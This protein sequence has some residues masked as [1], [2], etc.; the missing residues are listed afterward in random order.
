MH[1]W[2]GEL[3]VIV[4]DPAQIRFSTRALRLVSFDASFLRADLGGAPIISTL[5]GLLSA[6]GGLA[7]LPTRLIAAALGSI[8]LAVSTW[9]SLV[10][11]ATAAGDLI[12]AAAGSAG[13]AA[14][15][16]A[17][18]EAPIAALGTAAGGAPGT[19]SASALATAI[20]D[21]SEAIASVALGGAS[22]AIGSAATPT[23][24][25]N[26]DPRAG[27][28]L[29]LNLSLEI[30]ALATVGVIDAAMR[31]A[32]EV[33]AVAAATR[34]AADIDFESRDEA[35][36]WTA[37]LSE[38][39]DRLVGRAGELAPDAPAAAAISLSALG[40]VAAALGSDMNEI[41]GRL[42]A[43]SRITPA[44]T[45]SAWLIAQHLAGD[46]P[47]N[48]VAM[49]DDIVVRNRLRH[50]AQISPDGVEVLL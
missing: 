45:V 2:L 50:P 49:L 13:H 46:S 24:A 10:T 35:L 39:I 43:V 31:M 34:V 32:A 11:S 37:R 44:G 8:S 1:P 14:Q 4:A 38:G 3:T 19:A 33:A 30:D 29:L 22:P 12:Q 48:V 17:A 28:A 47:A 5:A 9:S 26:A 15:L 25:V 40:A 20:T 36:A 23:T 16:T 41:I 7:T 21:A 27:A 42:P 18:I 6:I